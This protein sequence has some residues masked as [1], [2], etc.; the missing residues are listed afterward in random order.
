MNWYIDFLSIQPPAVHWGLE[1]GSTLSSFLFS[2]TFK[3]AVRMVLL[4]K[5]N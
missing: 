4:V 5:M 3:Y 1:W 2:L